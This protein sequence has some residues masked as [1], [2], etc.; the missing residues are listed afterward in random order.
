MNLTP[1]HV[2][3]AMLLTALM[4]L[5]GAAHARSASNTLAHCPWGDL[6]CRNPPPAAA[7]NSLSAQPAQAR[8]ACDPDLSTPDECWTN[9]ETEDDITICDIIKLDTFLPENPRQG[10]FK[11]R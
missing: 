4:T 6:G 11:A 5:G 10:G 2:A 9:C 8:L 3:T 1:T 7:L